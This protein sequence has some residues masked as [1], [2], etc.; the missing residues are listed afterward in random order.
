[1]QVYNSFQEM[2]AGQAGAQGTMSV[3]NAN[4]CKNCGTIFNDDDDKKHRDEI[5][6]EIR[7]GEQRARLEDPYAD[8]PEDLEYN[9]RNR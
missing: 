5:A 1:M 2:A 4:Y 8:R 7:R 3:F 9:G 6:A